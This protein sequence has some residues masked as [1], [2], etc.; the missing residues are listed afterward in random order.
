MSTGFAKSSGAKAPKLQTD[1]GKI[2]EARDAADS[3]SG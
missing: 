3:V 2:M 1:F